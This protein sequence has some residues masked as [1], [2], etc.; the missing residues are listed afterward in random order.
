MYFVN[1][2]DLLIGD[3]L[4]YR[5]E[6]PNCVQKKIQQKTKSPYTHAAIY[7]GGGYIA[8]SVAWPF[9]WGVR[10]YKLS[11]SIKGS[12]CIAI[13]RNQLGFNPFRDNKLQEFV[14]ITISNKKFYNLKSAL[15]LESRASQY[16]GNQLEYI[17]NNFNLVESDSSYYDRSFFCSSFVVACLAY[18]GIIGFSARVAYNPNFFSPGALYKDPTFGWFLGYLSIKN[19]TVS[20]ND[21]ILKNSTKWADNLSVKWW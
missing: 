10:R 9:L 3:I 13:F 18:V 1:P 17:N 14:N 11:K 20:P 5:P 8:E 15:H 16:F 6:F 21:P 19:G 2:S 4:L 7:I 12:S